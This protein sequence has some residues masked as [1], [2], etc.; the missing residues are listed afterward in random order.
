MI[1]VGQYDSPFVRRVAV[2]LHHYHMPFTRNTMSVFGDAEDMQKINPLIRVPS[3]I[4][5]SGET[6]I[7]SSA[8][9]DCLDEMAGPARALMPPHGPQRRK[10]LQATVL[11]LGVCDKAVSLFFERHFHSAKSVS[12]EWESRCLLQLRAA[13]EKLEHD[14]GSPWYFDEHMTQADVS[15]GCMVGYLKLR[16]PEVFPPDSYP[17]LHALSLH[18][19]TRDEFVKSRMSPEETIPARKA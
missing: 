19:E 2:T 8:I 1:L 6:L 7:D 5:E 11:A 13:I 16:V 9:I 3:L 17:K 12:K 15:A 18:C 14:C 4:L 10:V